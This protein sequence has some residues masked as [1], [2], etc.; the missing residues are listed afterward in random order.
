M[1][2]AVLFTSKV[3]AWVAVDLDQEAFET[4][5]AI[6]TVSGMTFEA[7]IVRAITDYTARKD[8]GDIPGD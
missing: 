7:V 3:G 1:I 2:S 5:D 8:H 6:A 4:L